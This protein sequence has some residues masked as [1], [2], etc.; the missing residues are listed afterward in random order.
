VA[1]AGGDALG[2]LFAFPLGNQADQPNEEATHSRGGV[3]LLAH[4]HQF[5]AGRLKAFE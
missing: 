4:A 3:D 5:A 2:N 1:Y